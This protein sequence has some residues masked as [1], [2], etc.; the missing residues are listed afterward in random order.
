M[1]Q[2]A[3]RDLMVAT[4]EDAEP[5]DL[6]R[7]S[8]LDHCTNDTKGCCG[9]QTDQTKPKSDHRDFAALQAQ[10]RATLN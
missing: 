5:W 3:S 2:F 10:L 6:F 7:I 9:P 1:H 8:C 4:L